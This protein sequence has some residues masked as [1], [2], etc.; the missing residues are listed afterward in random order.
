[1][2]EVSY[3]QN[4]LFQ[5]IK[6]LVNGMPVQLVLLCCLTL[7]FL[8][9]CQQD[10]GTTAVQQATPTPLPTPVVPEK[11]TYT[12][13]QGT[14]LD[15]LDFTG[16][17]SPI[18]EQELFFKTDGYVD[19]V[20]VRRGDT[21]QEG[22]ILAQL[23]ISNLEEQLTQAQLALQTAEI[24]LQKAIKE[25]ED[26]L[27]EA[28][29]NL[30]KA[31]L[32]LNQSQAENDSASLI[33][34]SVDLSRAQERVASAAYEYQK[35]RDRHWESEE[36]LDSY[37]HILQQA[38]EELLIA[39]ARYNDTVATD[40][41]GNFDA[42]AQ[43]LDLQLAQ[44]RV[45][46]L[47]RGVDPLLEL[48]VE[49]ARLDVAEIERQI[50]DAQLIAPFT[51]EILSVNVRPG[52]RA[53]AFATVMVLA[54]PGDL[55][56]T[57]SLGAEQLEEMSIDQPAVIQLRNRPE[58]EFSGTV[59]SLPYPYGGG[60]VGE[61]SEDDA[62][63]ITPDTPIDLELGDLANVT[64]TLEKKDDALWLPPAAIRTFQGRTFVVIEENGV[65][66][67]VD[68]RLGIE[69]DDRV[70]ILEGLEAGQTVIGE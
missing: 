45:D 53:E 37:S 29:I 19:Q 13:E 62:A 43:Q 56:I 49:K 59:R 6:L 2:S 60:A 23:E 61:A 34:A 1:M 35:A 14:V 22:D 15:T 28:Q 41:T 55:E 3:R 9:G 39:E 30:E 20:L 32:Q 11:P 25:L 70:E 27:L 51:G 52:D 17:V 65:Q 64:I 44:L 57:A 40:N 5:K 63:R 50:A 16:R 33:S 10:N 67:R 54:D 12:V 38:E 48:D 26:N 18:L 42:R 46:Q 7:L 36:V 21:I 58:E 24:R 69:S 8:I 47:E 68:V 66:R 4:T 31:Q